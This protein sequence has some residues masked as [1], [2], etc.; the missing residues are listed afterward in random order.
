MQSIICETMVTTCNLKCYSY[1]DSYNNKKHGPVCPD[2]GEY[3]MLHMGFVLLSNPEIK[4]DYFCTDMTREIRSGHEKE[5]IRDIET[6]ECPYKG[7]SYKQIT[8]KTVEFVNI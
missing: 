8:T 5:V 4:S 6:N 3:G 1:I 7:K 2:T